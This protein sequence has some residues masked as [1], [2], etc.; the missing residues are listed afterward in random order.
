MDHAG[1]TE[2]KKTLLLSRLVEGGQWERVLEF[3]GEV[4]RDDPENG[5]AHQMMAQAA[6]N[7]DR[8]RTARRHAE[9]ALR[10]EAED[11]FSHVLM[12]R[13]HMRENR[14]LKAKQSLLDA[15]RLDSQN[16]EVWLHYGWNCLARGDALSAREVGEQARS[17]APLNAEVEGFMATVMNHTHQAD[18]LKGFAA[19]EEQEKALRL[20]PENSS[21]H[22]F[23]G[24]IYLDDLDDADNAEEAFRRALLLDPGESVYRE[25]LA[26]A[27]RRKDWALRILNL[28][29]HLCRKGYR[30]WEKYHDK[31]WALALALPLALVLAGPALMLMAVW[32]VFLWVPARVYEYLTVTEL[33]KKAGGVE[34][35]RGGF[36]GLH[37]WPFWVRFGL[38]VVVFAGFVTGVFWLFTAPGM[39]EVI[40]N[41][42][43]GGMIVL[44]L[45]GFWWSARVSKGND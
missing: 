31:G 17:L 12:A 27:L 30:V 4:L 19:I 24:R 43:G 42:L 22:Y 35:V 28:P 1:A 11:S 25:A 13:V 15:L 39:K 7:V 40:G 41:V 29:M 10:C 14:L 8:P 2:A 33:L 32:I 16:A 34:R 37:G 38:F 3:G 9:A 44:L 45:V 5:W 26:E 21:I 23:I 18:R 6:L 20:N 36:L